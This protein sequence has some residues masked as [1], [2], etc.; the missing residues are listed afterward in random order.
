MTDVDTP[1]TFGGLPNDYSLL[2]IATAQRDGKT[3]SARKI[4]DPLDADRTITLHNE[5][6]VLRA[7][8]R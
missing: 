6:P 2:L 4:I 8:G 1:F 5:D 7:T 3:W